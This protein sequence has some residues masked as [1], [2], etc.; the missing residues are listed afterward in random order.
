MKEREQ[1][2]YCMNCQHYDLDL[3]YCKNK[4]SDYYQLEMGYKDEC[5]EHSRG[6][7]EWVRLKGYG[8]PSLRSNTRG[9][10]YV[11]LKV[12]IPTKLSKEE[13]EAVKEANAAID[14]QEAAQA[15]A[16]KKAKEAAA[17]ARAEEE[18]KAAAAAKA[19]GAPAPAAKKEGK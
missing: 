1:K 6:K 17:V 8:V 2:K 3:M 5:D 14:K 9:D 16:E 15:E 19:A 12:E 7:M 10:Q 4:E 18:K 11:E 13:K